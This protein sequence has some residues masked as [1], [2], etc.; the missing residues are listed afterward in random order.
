[1]ARR[2]ATQDGRSAGESRHVRLYYFLLQSPAYRSLSP[3][4]RA[5]L[6]ELQALFDGK[7]NGELFLSVREAAK[8]INT[9]NATAG[10]AFLELE[11]HGFIR[12]NTPGSFNR[13]TRHATTW[14]LTEFQHGGRLATKDFMRWNGR[15][16]QNTVSLVR[17]I[18]VTGE[19]VKCA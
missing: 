5:L 4:G 8:R 9:S 18:G 17:P 14:I 2:K 3:P 6:V 11:E 19:T 10:R 15:E 13:K 12:K 1:M 16:I 7:N